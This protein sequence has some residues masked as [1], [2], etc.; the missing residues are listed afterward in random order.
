[1]LDEFLNFPKFLSAVLS[2]VHTCIYFLTAITVLLWI[3]AFVQGCCYEDG[4]CIG[5][6]ATWLIT[7]L[8]LPEL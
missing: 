6:I 7:A 5:S 4:L 3:S 8:Y 1:L 2:T